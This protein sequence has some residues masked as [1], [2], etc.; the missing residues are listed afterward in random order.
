MGQIKNGF[1]SKHHILKSFNVI[2]KA[3]IK[4]SSQSN[5]TILN[6]YQKLIKGH[7]EGKLSKEEALQRTFKS[8]EIQ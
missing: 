2:T 4:L 7:E 3:Q 1:G 5:N 8:C 6:Q